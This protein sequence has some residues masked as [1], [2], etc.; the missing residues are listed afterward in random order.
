MNKKYLR[1]CNIADF[2][3]NSYV[4]IKLNAKFTTSE[5]TENHTTKAP[6]KTCQ[7]QHTVNP[8]AQNN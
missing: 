2:I 1:F 8:N 3:Y 4:F 6:S 7:C 5:Q